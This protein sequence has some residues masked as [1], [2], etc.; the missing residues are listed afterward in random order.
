MLNAI[1][2]REDPAGDA[3]L[4]TLASLLPAEQIALTQCVD[5]LGASNLEA[6]V[7]L[8][9]A[10]RKIRT[11]DSW[12]HYN[13]CKYLNAMVGAG[14]S[15]AKLPAIIHSFLALDGLKD[16]MRTARPLP[17]SVLARELPAFARP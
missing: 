14:V 12:L 3:D 9:G 6:A 15:A 11:D 13:L 10:L 5:G 1:F 2:L 17:L 7:L 16:D 8:L 4:D